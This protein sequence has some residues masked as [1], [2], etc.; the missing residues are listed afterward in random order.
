LKVRLISIFIPFVNREHKPK[1]T[2]L[3]RALGYCSCNLLMTGS[4]GLLYARFDRRRQ[5]ILIVLFH[6]QNFI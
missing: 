3:I 6:I 5:V 2:Q 1:K 4:L